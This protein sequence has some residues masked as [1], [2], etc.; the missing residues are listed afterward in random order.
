MKNTKLTSVK[1]LENL[2]N[3]FN[4]HT[5]YFDYETNANLS[6]ALNIYQIIFFI[7]VN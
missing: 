5:D 2:Y 6:E 4:L 1:L 3:K 7:K